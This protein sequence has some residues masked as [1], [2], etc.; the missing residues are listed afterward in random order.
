MHKLQ[1]NEKARK[2]IIGKSGPFREKRQTDK[3]M[4]IERERREK[5]TCIPDSKESR[6]ELK[7][8][9]RSGQADR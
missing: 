2:V 1:T 9:Q 4:S 5:E 8:R 3:Q 7:R 6:R